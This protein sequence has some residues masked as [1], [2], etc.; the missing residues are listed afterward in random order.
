MQKSDL[1][2]AYLAGLFDGEGCISFGFA[3]STKKGVTY[4]SPKIQVSICN[5]NQKY[6][7]LLWEKAML[8]H[9]YTTPNN[10]FR[11]RDCTNW[12]D[13]TTWRINSKEEICRF[14]DLIGS[15]CLLKEKYITL[16]RKALKILEE[17]PSSLRDSAFQQVIEESLGMK[18]KASRGR[19]RHVLRPERFR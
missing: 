13:I 10:R 2:A 3:P 16:C 19:K 4:W 14:L 15:Y 12:Q 17:E 6:M 9:V 5:T 7:E 8:G 18:K 11:D 1:D